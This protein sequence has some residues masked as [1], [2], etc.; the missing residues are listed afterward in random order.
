MPSNDMTP[1]Q[2][3]V[4][5]YELLLIRPRKAK[6]IAGDLGLSLRATY[7]LLGNLGIPLVNDGGWWFLMSGYELADIFAI[8]QRIRESASA[9]AEDEDDRITVTLV[10][11]E[12]RAVLGAIERL[13]PP[14][15]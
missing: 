1:Q 5:V 8:Y 11:R 7:D 15:P 12:A 6:E 4:R 2:R 3:A 9:A 10:R 14:M 13:L